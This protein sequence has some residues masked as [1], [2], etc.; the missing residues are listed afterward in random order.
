LPYSSG[1]SGLIYLVTA[2]I[3]GS[4]FLSYAVRLRKDT[5]TNLPMRVFRYSI[6]YLMI[7]FTAL[8]IDHYFIIRI[9]F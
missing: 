7:L 4:T 5:G 1:M 9:D 8:L 3:L 6:N 2:L